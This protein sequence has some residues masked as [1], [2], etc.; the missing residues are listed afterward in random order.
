MVSTESPAVSI[1]KAHV[2]AWSHQDWE[3]ARNLLADDVKVLVNTTQPIMA[4]VNTTGVDDYMK[5]LVYFA[6]GV[7]PGS[8][9][10]LASTG[11]QHNALIILTVE[12]DFGG[13]KVTLPGARLYLIDE[14]DKIKSEQVIF[15][16]AEG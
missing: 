11:D 3:T 6:S 9:R 1:A 2:E 14:N 4:P 10:V 15:Y 8:A 13:N 16:A 12:A 7:T 5:G